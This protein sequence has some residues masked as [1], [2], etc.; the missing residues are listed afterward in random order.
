MCLKNTTL[1]LMPIMVIA[2]CSCFNPGVQWGGLVHFATVCSTWVFMC[3]GSTG[4]SETNPMGKKTANNTHAN[5]MVTRMIILLLYC[6]ANRVQWVLEQPASSLM[7]LHNRFHTLGHVFFAKTFMGAFGAK[8][9]KPTHL[10]GS[11][12]WIMELQAHITKEQAAQL[13]SSNVTI[14][15]VRPDGRR[16]VDG[17]SQL[18]KTQEYPPGYGIAVQKHWEAQERIDDVWEAQDPVCDADESELVAKWNADSWVD[19]ELQ[20]IGDIVP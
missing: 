14:N 9:R 1:K 10:F 11:H 19:A 8:T 3:R 7:H 12:K 5:V 6:I 16:S 15:Y 2:M 4:R 17:G 18:K 13:D 20:W